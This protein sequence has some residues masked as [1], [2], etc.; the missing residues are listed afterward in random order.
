VKRFAELVK[1]YWLTAVRILIGVLL[2]HSGWGKVSRPIAFFE[3]VINFYQIVPDVLVPYVAWALAW[4]EFVLGT[5]LVLGFLTNVSAGILSGL[6]F[7]FEM[8]VAQAIVRRLPIEE[9]GCFGGGTVHL[10]L[11]QTFTLEVIL[12]CLLLQIASS[13]RYPLSLDQRL[14]QP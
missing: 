12:F 2:I 9:C 14:K 5:F 1:T 13:R 11:I 3:I 6:I 7:L 10:T 4:T 8:V